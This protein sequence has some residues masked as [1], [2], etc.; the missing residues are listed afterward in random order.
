MKG[1][2]LDMDA[3]IAQVP[4][5]L[6][7][8]LHIL[9]VDEVKECDLYYIPTSKNAEELVAK[10]RET[11][12]FK[13]V[14]MLPN[15]SIEYPITLR[16]GVDIS[17]RRFDVRKLM[18]N[19]NYETVY[20]NS[21]GWLLNSIVFSSLG[22]KKSRNIFVE[23]GI[24]PYIT[25]YDS[26]QWYLRLFINLSGMTCMDGRF[27]DSRY[28][29][30]PSLMQVE[31]KGEI[32]PLKKFDREDKQFK[33]NINRIF[34]DDDNYLDS[35]KDK[36]IIIMEQ[37]PRKEPIDMYAL[38]KKVSEFIPMDKT[39]VKSH[40]RQKQGN[41]SG[42]GFEVYKRYVTPWEVISLNQDMSN[43]TLMSIFST[44][45]IYPKIMYDDEP[46]VIMLYKL[47]G[48]DYT[49]FGKGMIGFVEGVGKLYRDKNRFFVP[50]TWNELELYCKE[51]L[52]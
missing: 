15:I 29:F 33:E 23:N 3:Y 44:S 17:L 2:E 13:N 30:E 39:I 20:Y 52:W 38:W 6:M 45:C 11:G 32:V 36:E 9:T 16:Q 46:R 40:P 47:I 43:K 22:N 49:F 42:L 50:E 19:K 28:I 27:I 1:E 14:Y 7:F 48:F 18:K 4:L 31:Q 5:H 51:Y 34:G 26:K 41:L 21:D 8:A 35:F 10:A 25:P 12:L 24:N 37:G